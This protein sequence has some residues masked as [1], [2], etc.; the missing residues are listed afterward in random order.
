MDEGFYPILTKKTITSSLVKAGCVPVTE[1]T[2][3]TTIP[4]KNTQV[5][6]LKFHVDH[7]IEFSQP[8]SAENALDRSL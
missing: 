2:E 6:S 7:H 1:I 3:G 4:S 5:F 8:M